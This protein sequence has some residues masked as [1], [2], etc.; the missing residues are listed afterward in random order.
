[1]KKRKR[2]WEVQRLNTTKNGSRQ[3]PLKPYNNW[4]ITRT[5]RRTLTSFLFTVHK[6]VVPT[7]PLPLSLFTHTTP[8]HACINH[9]PLPPSLHS[10]FFP[11]PYF[12]C[13][14]FACPMWCDVM[15]WCHCF[16]PVCIRNAQ[17]SPS[18]IIIITK[19]TIGTCDRHFSLP[20]LLSFWDS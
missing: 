12:V 10:F 5:P 7:L 14:L 9:D 18:I 16:I 19:G 3:Y 2:K 4:C 11:F 1:M 6:D 8:F 20:M 13:C 15:M 17:P